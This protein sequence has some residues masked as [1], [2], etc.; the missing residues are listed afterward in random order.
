MRKTAVFFLPILTLLFM[1]AKSPKGVLYDGPYVKYC[2]DQ[3]FVCYVYDDEGLKTVVT[4]S[5]PLAK[6]NDIVLNVATDEPGKTFTVKLKQ[7]PLQNEKN[8]T[9]KVNKQ[10]VVSDM[11]GN[12]KAFRTLL[13]A[14][15]IIDSAFNWTFGDGHLVLTGDFFD[16]GFQ[17]TE[18]LWLIYSL[19]DKAK[20]AGGY[21]HYVLGNHEIM[22]MSNDLRYVHPKYIQNA[23]IMGTSYLSFYDADSELGR[24]LRTKNVAEVVGN[25][26]YVHGGISQLV[27]ELNLSVSKINKTVRPHYADSTGKY[28]DTR[29]EILYSDLGPFWYR[30][31]YAGNEKATQV[32]V[33][34]TLAQYNVKYI[35]TGHTVIADTISVLYNG[36]VFNTDI[37]H[38]KQVPQG[39]L[40][41]NGKFYRATATGERL[42][43][44]N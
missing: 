3:V 16:R 31:Y 22:N 32:Q 27:N 24:W 10:F 23:A 21:V 14:N 7:A 2:R 29:T 18:L 35:A 37:H 26:L 20:A 5:F 25:V 34:N 12:F 15:Q 4:D 13:Q 44:G 36:K 17:Q 11:E 6:K 39:L 42:Q 19:E 1:G 30:G 28:P 40:I 33:D 8:E 38:A 43:I 41:E 9:G